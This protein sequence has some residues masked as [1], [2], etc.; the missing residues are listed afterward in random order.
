MSIVLN[1]HFD[2]IFNVNLFGNGTIHKLQCNT[3]FIKEVYYINN[4]S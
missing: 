4:G 1:K 2:A 3:I